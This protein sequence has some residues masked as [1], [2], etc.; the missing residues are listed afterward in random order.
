MF[1]TLRQDL[2]L[3]ALR[4]L[5]SLTLKGRES[6]EKKSSNTG[7]VRRIKKKERKRR[8][9]RRRKQKGG[10]APFLIPLTA[11]I[12]KAVVSELRVPR[13][14]TVSKNISRERTTCSPKN[15]EPDPKNI[16]EGVTS[17]RPMES[18]D[19]RRDGEQTSSET[20]SQE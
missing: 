17:I 3:H 1:S 9:R 8:R 20:K 19:E 5:P 6:L 4:R 13:S 18:T 2:R 14:V 10:I 11:L 7:M 12:G 16:K 15:F